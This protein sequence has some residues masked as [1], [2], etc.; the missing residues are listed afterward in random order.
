MY[1]ALLHTKVLVVRAIEVCATWQGS[2]KS[3][4]SLHKSYK[5]LCTLAGLGDVHSNPFNRY[6]T[7]V[8][9]VSSVGRDEHSWLVGSSYSVSAANPQLCLAGRRGRQPTRC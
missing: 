1:S 3:T 6:S 9:G 4:V 5:G 2:A 8:S 7:M